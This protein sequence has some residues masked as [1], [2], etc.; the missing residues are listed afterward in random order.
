MAGDRRTFSD[1]NSANEM[2][3]VPVGRSEDTNARKAALSMFERFTDRARRVVVLAQEE[4][5]MLNHNYI[6]TEHILLALIREGGG[7]AA[8]ALES[9][10][11]TEEAARQQVEEIVGRGQEGPQRGHLPFTPQAKKTLQLSMREAIALGHAYIGTEHILLGLVREDDGVAVRVL[12][13][14]GVDPNRVRQQVIQLVSAR[15]VQEEPETGRAAGRGKR[16]LLSELRGRLDA[17]DWRLSVLEQRVGT[18]PD[19]GQLDQEI[20]QVRR[21]KESA[22]D[23][24]DFE[25]AAVLRDREQQL[26]GD[27]AARQQEWT[28]LPS[29]SDE[30]ERLRDLLHRYGIDPQDGVA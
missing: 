15:R 25:N 2:Y 29:L 12:N 6:G 28:S 27:K 14:L 11:I 13:G 19:L 3:R 16:K 26:L 4:A 8:R 23:V 10:G 17:L 20:S 21:D 18:S 5:R 9:L 22:V 30:V 24:Q 1:A 7:V